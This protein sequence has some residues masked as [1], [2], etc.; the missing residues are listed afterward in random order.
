MNDPSV[1]AT[2]V[3][4]ID[5]LEAAIR[6]AQDTMQPQLGKAVAHLMEVKKKSLNLDGKIEHDLDREMWL[7]FPDWRTPGDTADNYDLFF[8]FDQSLC[9]DGEETTTW[10]GNFCG[11]GGAGIRFAFHSN[12]LGQREWKNLLRSERDILDQIVALGLL[13]DPKTGEL[14]QLVTLDRALLADAFD[15][16]EFDEALAPIKAALDRIETMRPLLDKLVM[17]IRKKVR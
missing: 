6:F 15:D 8:E 1:G 10:V 5:E 13:C 16:E 17:A 9:I 11:F 4:H 14:A 12:A 2:I 7:A 3:R